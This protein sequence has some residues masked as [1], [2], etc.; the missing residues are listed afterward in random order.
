MTSK[1]GSDHIIM[2]CKY[3]TSIKR[4][5]SP[6]IVNNQFKLKINQ[7]YYVLKKYVE[8]VIMFDILVNFSLNEMGLVC[9]WV[10]SMNNFL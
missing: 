6:N 9:F 10:C 3:W 5:A 1:T 7:Y 2:M 4:K 8:A